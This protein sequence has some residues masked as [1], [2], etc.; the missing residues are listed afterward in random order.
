MRNNISLILAVIGIFILACSN[1][2]VRGEFKLI[3]TPEISQE[4]CFDLDN[5]TKTDSIHADICYF[6]GPR[7]NAPVYLAM[8]NNTKK[9][10]IDKS[11]NFEICRN[12]LSNFSSTNIPDF[13]DVKICVLTN[14]NQ[15]SFLEFEDGFFTSRLNNAARHLN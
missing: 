15:L 6:Q 11:E 5:N 14:E 3:P 13:P 2:K 12:V 4:S 10:L 1:T 7:S 9:Y 8:V